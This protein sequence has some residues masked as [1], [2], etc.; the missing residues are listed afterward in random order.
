[1]PP[2]V[3]VVVVPFEIEHGVGG[4]HG[5][6]HKGGRTPNYTEGGIFHAF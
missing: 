6:Y 4:C 2:S 3:V 5:F 1:M